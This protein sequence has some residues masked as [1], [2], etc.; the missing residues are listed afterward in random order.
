MAALAALHHEA[1]VLDQVVPERARVHVG[2]RVGQNQRW[3]FDRVEQK[4]DG[5]AQRAVVLGFEPIEVR[6]DP[7]LSI[8]DPVTSK[9]GD[10]ELRPQPPPRDR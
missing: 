4:I 8:R 5:A 1:E 9:L 6:C 2:A 7:D 10:F 3:I